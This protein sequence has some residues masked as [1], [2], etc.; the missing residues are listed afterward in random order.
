[1]Q[2]APGTFGMAPPANQLPS[3]VMSRI[4][5]QGVK[6]VALVC[7]GNSDVTAAAC[8]TMED[9][10]TFAGMEVHSFLLYPDLLSDS[11]V[12]FILTGWVYTY[13]RLPGTA[14]C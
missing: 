14:P 5:V 13:I 11:N 1:M 6:R 12:I 10:I 9:F 7:A 4:A 8:G 2:S 3:L